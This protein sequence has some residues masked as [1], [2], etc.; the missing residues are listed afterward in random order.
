MVALSKF[1][2][3][4]IPRGLV[5]YPTVAAELDAV[6]ARKKG[7][8]MWGMTRSGILRDDAFP[9]EVMRSAFD[10]GLA[11]VLYPEE[12]SEL[13]KFQGITAYVLHLDQAWRIPAQRVLY[14]A[15]GPWTEATTDQLG[16]LLG[17]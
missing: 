14:D 17:Y 11:L 7:M 4:R 16:Q 1:F 6:A 12:R 3:R 10:R 13:P 15:R 8:S 2:K 9:H 5:T